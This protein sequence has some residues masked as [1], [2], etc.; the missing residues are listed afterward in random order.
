VG[1]VS[2]T[3]EKYLQCWNQKDSVARRKQIDEI[4]AEG[5]GYVDPLVQV[6]GR[7]SLD[8]VIAGAQNQFGGLQFERGTTYEEHHNVARFTWHLVSAPGTDPVAVGFDVVVR[9][10]VSSSRRTPEKVCRGGWRFCVRFRDG[11]R[12]DARLHRHRSSSRFLAGRARTAGVWTG[13]RRTA[14]SQPD[15]AQL[16]T[17]AAVAES[18]GSQAGQESNAP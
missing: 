6:T 15:H 2:D 7:E 3:I 1:E 16:S 10:I 12:R 9:T 13:L 8:E 5:A 18:S 17:D 11:N 4:W 14:V